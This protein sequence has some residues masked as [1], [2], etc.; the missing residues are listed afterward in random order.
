MQVLLAET[1]ESFGKLLKF[2]LEQNEIVV[3]WLVSGDLIDEY[4]MYDEYDV[5]LISQSLAGE[6]GFE[7][8]QSLREKGF[9]RGIMIMADKTS[10]EDRIRGYEAGVDDY[11]MKPFDN[12][13]LAAK[14][15][16]LGRRSSHALLENV[17]VI[18]D[19]KL[20]RNAKSVSRRKKRLQLSPREFQLFDLLVQNAGIAV[21]REIILDR[22][23]GLETEVSTNNVDAY[24]KL[25]R[26]KIGLVKG[27]T[28]IKTVRGVGYMLKV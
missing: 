6:T 22:V 5:L 2:V 9:S 19:L 26:K 18:G 12:R 28:I 27:K 24:I 10:A 4:A 25:L 8:C 11:I 14:I 15:K 3:E 23:W 17:V 20:D 13:E 16:A 7:V 1:D 21:S